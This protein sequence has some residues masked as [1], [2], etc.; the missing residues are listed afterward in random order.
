MATSMSRVE[1]RVDVVL[2]YPHVPRIRRRNGVFHGDTLG[3][4]AFMLAYTAPA[5][6]LRVHFEIYWR[7]LY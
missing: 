4:W 3:L 1:F 5:G 7:L 2:F 6:A